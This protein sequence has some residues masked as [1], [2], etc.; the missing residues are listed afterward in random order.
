MVPPQ[1]QAAVDIQKQMTV[2]LAKSMEA[3]PL[4]KPKIGARIKYGEFTGILEGF[5][6][7]GVWFITWEISSSYRKIRERMG[8]PIPQ[9]PLQLKESFFELMP[10][11]LNT[12]PRPSF[13]T[14][15]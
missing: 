5:A 10:L 6:P 14:T 7:N 12:S 4:R 15:L 8:T 1:A 13:A 9:L 3:V 11:S 2:A